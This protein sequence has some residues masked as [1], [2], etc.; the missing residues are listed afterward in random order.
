MDAE[1]MGMPPDMNHLAICCGMADAAGD[2]L[3][4]KLPEVSKPGGERA[5]EEAGGKVTDPPATV[6][7]ILP[8][9]CLRP[10]DVYVAIQ[11]SR[12]TLPWG[13]GGCSGGPIH[14][15]LLVP[16]IADDAGIDQ[17]LVVFGIVLVAGKHDRPDSH[18]TL[19]GDC[20]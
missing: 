2:P 16:A 3:E 9:G 11:Q 1:V 5:K 20:K 19:F 12:C 6:D 13:L 17:Y 4:V 14:P 18:A 8:A 15:G 7:Q 10:G